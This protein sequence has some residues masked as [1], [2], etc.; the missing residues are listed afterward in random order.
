MA[1]VLKNERV[2]AGDHFQDTRHIELS[3]GD[4]GLTYEPGSLLAVFPQQDASAVA[5]FCK[6]ARLNPD[7][8][9]RVE[10]EQVLA[11]GHSPSIAVR[12]SAAPPLS[13]RA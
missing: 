5:A 7:D 11:N 13:K 8:W 9:I 12:G 1:Q 10:P 2:T 4:S 6:R 3:L